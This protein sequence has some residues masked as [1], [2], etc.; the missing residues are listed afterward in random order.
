MC[1]QT[2]LQWQKW[3]FGWSEPLK[4]KVGSMWQTIQSLSLLIYSLEGKKKQ[5]KKTEDNHLIVWQV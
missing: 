2:S 5:K 1:S 4:L 3:D